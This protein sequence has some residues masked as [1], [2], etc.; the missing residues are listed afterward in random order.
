MNNILI[1]LIII[2]LIVIIIYLSYNE[3]KYKIS[4]LNTEHLDNINKPPIGN[5]T[6][7]Y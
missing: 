7:F 6:H 2:I 5:L 3:H 1:V 4:Y